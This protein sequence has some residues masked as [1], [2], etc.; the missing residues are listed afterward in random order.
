MVTKVAR[1]TTAAAAQ[2]VNR[3]QRLAPEERAGKILD[4]AAKL[5]LEEGF[6]EV[7]MERLGREAG[8]SKALVYNYFPNR[9]VLL[10][11]LLEREIDLLHERQVLQAKKAK[12]FRD[13]VL[14]TTRF[15]VE[16]L[17]ERGP[18]LQRLWAEP[19]VARTVTAK[20][21]ARRDEAMRYFASKVSE[22]YCLPKEVA[23][24][25]VDMQMALTEAAAQHVS[26]SN[27]D[28]DF[29]VDICV[30]L[31]MGGLQALAR[32]HGEPRARKGVAANTTASRKPAAKARKSV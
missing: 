22:E 26:S 4:C 23:L 3:R 16:H 27:E 29:A 8:I 15:Y 5:I 31:L 7:S 18:L 21:F 11:A 12:N 20:K 9:T 32:S 6:T 17:R 10:R 19:T 1:K 30:R 25:A 24:A 28:V 2:P 13:L 14:R